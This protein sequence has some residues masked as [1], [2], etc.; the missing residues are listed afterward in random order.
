MGSKS[1]GPNMGG[2]MGQGGD[3]PAF[4][5]PATQPVPFSQSN[6]MMMQP[7]RPNITPEMMAA[8]QSGRG[9]PAFTLGGQLPPP[10]FQ[11]QGG[12]IN[13]NV[14]AAIM[15]QQQQR[16]PMAGPAMMPQRPP[17]AGPAMMPQR[18]APR[19]TNP[20]I[21]LAQ[22]LGYGSQRPPAMS[23]EILNALRL[24]QTRNLAMPQTG[25]TP[26]SPQQQYVQSL[27]NGILG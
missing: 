11:P 10:M 18:P 7:P 1:A 22:N 26:I 17:S 15:S 24:A 25:G 3:V 23:P 6:A 27:L 2:G 13:P 20:L 14:L 19:P 5:M 9:L 21:G 12:G 8:M 16:P 4:D